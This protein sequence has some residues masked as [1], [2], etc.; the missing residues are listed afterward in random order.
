M[1]VVA[2]N[3]IQAKMI[4]TQFEINFP[5]IQTPVIYNQGNETKEIIEMLKR[6]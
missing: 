4:S 6:L 2:Q 5:C 1:Y 3:K